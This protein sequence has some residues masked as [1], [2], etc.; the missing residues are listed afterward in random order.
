M[1]KAACFHDYLHRDH[2]KWASPLSHRNTTKILR[3]NKVRAESD[4]SR[5]K[6]RSPKNACVG[7]QVSAAHLI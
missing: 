7:G 2:G 1:D 5:L 6:T 3:G 4:R